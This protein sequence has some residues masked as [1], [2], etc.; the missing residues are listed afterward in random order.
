MRHVDRRICPG[1]DPADRQT[2]ACLAGKKLASGLAPVLLQ[3]PFFSSLN[4]MSQYFEI[5]PVTPQA[6]LIRGAVDIL[7]NGGVI[8]YPT[9]TAYALGCRIGDKAALDRI[10]RIRQLD[11]RHNFT[12]CCRDLSDI[13]KYAKVENYAYRLLKA[14]TPG[15]YT[16]ILQA[17]REVPRIMQ[18]PK[19]KTV[20]IRVP[21]HAITQALIAELGEPLMSSTLIL[22]EHDLP[23]TEPHEIRDRIEKVV[24]LIIDGGVGGLEPSTVVD[25]SQGSAEV[26]RHGAG[27]ASVFE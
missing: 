24:D 11:D 13:S 17:T 16:F 6:R 5:H 9:D 12:L 10:R 7:L 20:G 22:P 21:D 1:F 23:M 2:G 15:P 25:L 26:V 14:H 3:C 19:R 8:I 27:D 4:F 18:H